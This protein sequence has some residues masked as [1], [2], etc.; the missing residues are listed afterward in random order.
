MKTLRRFVPDIP[1]MPPIFW[2]VAWGMTA[3]MAASLIFT[4]YFTHL[5]HPRV[6]YYGFP[7]IGAGFQFCDFHVFQERSMY[8]RTPKYWN[9]FDYPFT[10][11]A[12]DAVLFAMIYKLPHPL[13]TYLILLPLEIAGWV[14]WMTRGFVVRGLPALQMAAF[15]LVIVGTSWPVYYVFDTANIEGFM[16]LILALGILAVLHDR[17]WLGTVLIVIAGA[18]KI[19]PLAL[20]ALLL[21][22]RRYKEF[23]AGLALCAGIFIGSLAILGPSIA[24]AQ[25]HLNVGTAF[26]RKNYI[27]LRGKDQLNFS[28]ALFNPL[29]Y[30]VLLAD[31]ILFHHGGHATPAHEQALLDGSLRVYLVATV[32]FGVVMYFGRLRKLPMLN[33]VIAL[34]VCAVVLTPFSSD[35]TLN[36]LLMPFGLLCFYTIDT[37]HKRR[38]MRPLKICFT[39]FCFIFAFETFFTWKYAFASSIRALALC[40]LLATVLRF[41]FATPEFDG[42]EDPENLFAH[43]SRPA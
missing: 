16:A 32:V 29:K 22:K 9:K 15:A 19:Y 42:P 2:R 31:R 39:C 28:H 40:V 36:N 21:S 35:Y 24:V 23:F 8:F 20:L 4:L 37:W 38:D 7:W 18:M 17:T 3:M 26:L 27:V 12:P 10:Y 14:A 25:A 33:Q 34:V 30:V 5:L 1:G 11:P 43:G 41:P 6:P 13:K